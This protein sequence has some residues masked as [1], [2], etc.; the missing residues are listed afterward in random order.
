M[1][2]CEKCKVTVR[3]GQDVCP[4]CQ[5][6]LSGEHDENEKLFPDIK[7]KK[8][9]HNLFLRWM[10]F[11]CFLAVIVC[12]AINWL[13]HPSYWW[14]GFVAAGA[15]MAWLSVFIGIRKRR[16]LLKNGLWQIM[17]LELALVIW[18]VATGWN[19]WSVTYFLPIGILTMLVFM[20]LIIIVQKLDTTHY[21]IYL[22]MGGALGLVPVIFLVLGMVTVRLPSVLCVGASLLMLAALFLFQPRAVREEFFKKFHL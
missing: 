9:H 11:G 2:Y 21:M 6:E 16:N 10:A 20:N 3:T 19:A 22:L 7:I 13:T 15:A 5:G 18:D 8:E 1:R 4:L 17:F 14:S 12:A